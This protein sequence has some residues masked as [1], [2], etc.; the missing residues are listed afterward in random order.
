MGEVGG[1]CVGEW[2]DDAFVHYAGDEPKGASPEVF[3]VADQVVSQR[4]AGEEDLLL[5]G[6]VSWGLGL[7]HDLPVQQHNLAKLVAFVLV[8]DDVGDDMHDDGRVALIGRQALDQLL[9]RS[10]LVLKVGAG[11]PGLQLLEVGR[12][13]AWTEEE[14]A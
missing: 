9:H 6:L 8:G 3:V 13:V 5:E 11:D 4:V 2:L 1:D 12:V 10:H 7:L 14:G